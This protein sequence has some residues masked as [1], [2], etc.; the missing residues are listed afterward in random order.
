MHDGPSVVDHRTLELSGRLPLRFLRGVGLPD[1]LIEYLP[2]L[3]NQPIQMYSCFLS[4]SSKDHSFAERLYADLQN[5]GVRC[6]FAPK[7]LRIGEKI[8]D[9]IDEEIRLRDKVLIILSENSIESDWVED[10]VNKAFSEERGTKKT[11]LF[12]L[13]ID[14][15]ILETREPWAR[16]LLDQRNIG[17]FRRWKDHDEYPLP[18]LPPPP[19]PSS[20]PL[21]PFS[22]PLPPL[23]PPSFSPP[24][25][26]PSQVS[27][28]RL[29]RDLVI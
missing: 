18:P 20:P 14:D 29:I 23:P 19:P 27:L 4:Y 25:P 13:R 22:S 21:P 9:T 11:I 16:K 2:S 5:S 15:A 26:F 1:L 28:K 6:W 10:E 17:D 24:L 7:D 12:P 8:W 3:L